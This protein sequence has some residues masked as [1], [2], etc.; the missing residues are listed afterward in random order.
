MATLL[1]P[2]QYSYCTNIIKQLLIPRTQMPNILINTRDKT[3]SRHSCKIIAEYVSEEDLNVLEKSYI[4]YGKRKKVKMSVSSNVVSVMLE[5]MAHTE[6]DFLEI[7][8][9]ELGGYT[10]SKDIYGKIIHKLVIVNNI[11]SITCHVQRA[12]AKFMDELHLYVRFIFTCNSLANIS[13]MLR[14]RCVMVRIPIISD[15]EQRVALKQKFNHE[16]TIISTNYITNALAT[17]CSIKG[18]DTEADMPWITHINKIVDI[19][20]SKKLSKNAITRVRCSYYALALFGYK[21]S[22]ILQNVTKTLLQRADIAGCNPAT[23]LAILESST[24]HCQLARR[25]N[26][27]IFYVEA[28]V[29]QANTILNNQP[30]QC[31]S[32]VN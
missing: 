26:K 6:P 3:M 12:L 18:I 32:M 4:S 2:K 27:G 14:S 16:P 11:N 30:K 8:L 31:I 28:F 22:I 15:D 23:I 21:T 29:L 20:H 24:R 17:E 9:A 7:L 25:G 5:D 1:L 13:Y 19:I 10:P